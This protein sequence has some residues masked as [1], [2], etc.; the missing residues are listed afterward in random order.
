MCGKAAG[1]GLASRAIRGRAYHQV[2][3]E[4]ISKCVGTCGCECL[5]D[6]EAAGSENDGEGEPEAAVGGKRGSTESIT[7]SH[8]PVRIDTVSAIPYTPG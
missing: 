6:L 5:F 7:N 8:F 4:L 3:P 2:E 1:A